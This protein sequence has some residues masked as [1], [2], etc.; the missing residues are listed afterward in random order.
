MRHVVG[1]GAKVLGA[2]C[3]GDDVKIGANAVVLSDLP[4]GSTAVGSKA[5]TITK[6]H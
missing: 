6:D 3:V 2:I 1:A 5:K 4:T